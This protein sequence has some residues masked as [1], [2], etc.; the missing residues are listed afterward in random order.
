MINIEK[1]KSLGPVN[2]LTK[3]GKILQKNFEDK[4]I[5]KKNKF[6]EEVLDDLERNHNHSWYDEIY[7]RNKNNLNDIALFYRGNEITY[8]EMFAN[9]QKYAKSLKQM[10]VKENAE[11]PICISNTPEFVYLL[12][13]ISMLGLKAN[14]FASDL[15]PDYTV[16]IINSCNSDIMFI[17]DRYYK[18][19]KDL[20]PKTKINK[21]IMPSITS[22]LPKTGNKYA[23]LDKK[24]GLFVNNVNK[25]QQENKNILSID[26]F[27]NLGTNYQDSI[28]YNSNLD[29]EFIISYSSGTT[30]NKPK[31]IVHTTRSLVTIGRCHD[32]EIQKTTS[33]KN[34][35]IQAHIPTF[36]NT[37]IIC[38][39]SDSLMQGSKLA[40]E[41]IYDKDFFI[42]T[43]LINK[44]TYI[45]ASR[46]YWLQ[47]FKKVFF[48]KEYKD[49]KMPFLLIPFA[50]GEGLDANEEK[51]LNK[52]LRK[53]DAG[54]KLVPLP[55]SVITMSVAGGDCEH[56]GIFWLLFRS[57][58]GKR[59]NYLLKKET[60]G[61]KAFEMVEYAV[62]DENGNKCK[63]YQYGR[64]VAN[65]PCTMKCYKNNPQATQDFFIKDATGK[66]WGDCCVYSYL[67]SSNGIHIKGRIPKE[68]DKIPPFIIADAILKDTKN[69]LSCEVV[70]SED[71]NFY[72]AH[73]EK[74]PLSH[75]NILDI[76]N[77]TEQRCEKIL[78]KDVT[79]KILY[80]IHS[81]KEAFPLTHSGKRDT[82]AIENE[83][84]GPK[85]FKI[86]NDNNNITCIP[87][88][89]YIDSMNKEKNKVMQKIR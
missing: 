39:I 13:A 52:G 67:D 14:V 60:P 21:I 34:F 70:K 80:R 27:I 46:C 12:G 71:K 77:S 89:E 54:K 49:V 44:P 72:I 31:P 68:N 65:S 5:I 30:S 55:T 57:L 6:I 58:Q 22:S 87:A 9:M 11:I 48:D 40:L 18:D 69:I 23:N 59:P 26:E 36:S 38:S 37:D 33:M 82:R 41:P 47:A 19:L 50:V 63:P 2:V 74:Q 8:K 75:K 78:G 76:I 45:V 86:I 29:D 84:I 42:D 73:I 64:L 7:S 25:Y 24:H 53:V 20:L 16:E 4:K 51:F 15:D 35:T 1:I 28:K 61:L 43:L 3:K 79:K 81:N 32:P 66:V 17:E 85:T 62:L 83:G 56:G 88:K 10:G